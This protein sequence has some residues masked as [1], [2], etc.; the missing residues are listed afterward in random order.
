MNKWII[1][2]SAYLGGSLSYA[3]ISIIDDPLKFFIV[4]VPTIILFTKEG[5][6]KE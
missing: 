2:A 4:L 3:G 1:M 5:A 6:S